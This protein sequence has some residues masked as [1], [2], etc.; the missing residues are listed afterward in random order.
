[1]VPELREFRTLTC[2]ICSPQ[3]SM[4]ILLAQGVDFIFLNCQV[5]RVAGTRPIIFS[6][7]KIAAW[8]GTWMNYWRTHIDA[9]SWI[10]GNCFAVKEA[11]VKIA[12]HKSKSIMK[13]SNVF[14]IVCCFLHFLYETSNGHAKQYQQH[15]IPTHEMAIVASFHLSSCQG[16]IFVGPAGS[17]APMNAWYRLWTWIKSFIVSLIE[18]MTSVYADNC[19]SCWKSK[20]DGLSALLWRLSKYHPQMNSRVR[21]SMIVF[22]FQS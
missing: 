16:R 12:R 18:L 7:S 17:W 9:K 14:S 3:H 13:S 5:T 21:T 2:M 11:L 22:S 4:P 15:Q 1:M 6:I 19:L 10:S 8:I 20:G